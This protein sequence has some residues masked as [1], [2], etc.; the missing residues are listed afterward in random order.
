MGGICTLDKSKTNASCECVPGTTKDQSSGL[1]LEDSSSVGSCNLGAGNQSSMGQ[2]KIS[3]V[4][5][6]SYYFYE[7]SV[8]AN[9]TP[10]WG[11]SQSAVIFASQ[12]VT[13]LLLFMG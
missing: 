7:D 5:Q 10:M 3:I 2:F 11:L 4:Q 13:V 6:T 9:Y 8:I 1:C 12:I